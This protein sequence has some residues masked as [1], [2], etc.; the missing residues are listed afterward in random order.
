MS[1][2]TA[3]TITTAANQRRGKAPGASACR[4]C[5][6]LPISIV[7]SCSC[8][9]DSGDVPIDIRLRQ[10]VH[11]GAFEEAAIALP[12][13]VVL[14][15]LAGTVHYQLRVAV[16]TMDALDD[17]I[18]HLKDDLDVETNTKVVTRVRRAG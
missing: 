15:H 17:L 4:T 18:R 11:E 7:T 16:T 10:G 9:R 8:S 2:S 6:S 1:T 13:A 3:P 12:G 14:E 5:S